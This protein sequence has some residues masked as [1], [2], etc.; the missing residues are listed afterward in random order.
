MSRALVGTALN[1][2]SLNR[3]ALPRLSLY[4]ASSHNMDGPGGTYSNLHPGDGKRFLF[5]IP[6]AGPP[7]G[8]ARLHR[9]APPTPAK[10]LAQD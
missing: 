1:Q 10:L 9:V 2:V 6:N 8:S 5:L 7:A 4:S 3:A